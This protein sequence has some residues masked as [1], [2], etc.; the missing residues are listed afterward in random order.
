MP[1]RSRLSV[2]RGPRR[3]TSWGAGPKS[4][5]NGGPGTKFTGTAGVL[6]SIVAAATLDGITLV[7]T[8]GEFLFYLDTAANLDDGFHGAIAI[9]IF[10][11]QATI[12]GVASLQTPLT[13]ETWDGWLWHQYF[14]CFSAGGISAAGVSLSG[15]QS[16]AAKAAVRVEVDSKAMR[17]FQV[18]QDMAVVIEVVEVG[19]ATASWTFNS[20][21]LFKLP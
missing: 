17:K 5:A 16:D 3:Q 6:G 18:G 1:R 14:S 7:R 8:R 20:R 21:T 10:N 2:S 13:D 11:D 12:A 4:A 9:G 15:G 19:D